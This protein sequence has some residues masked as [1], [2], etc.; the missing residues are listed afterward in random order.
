[1]RTND[2]RAT[3]RLRHPRGTTLW[4][5]ALCLAVPLSVCETVARTD[6]PQR[7]G[8]VPSVGSS[9]RQFE[10]AL[11]RIEA[12]VADEGRL[13][14][15]FLGSSVVH[16]GIDPAA[17]GGAYR[18][19]TG[20]T[21]R[22]FNFGIQGVSVATS[23][24]LAELL[25]RRYHPRLLVFG[26]TARD[27]SPYAQH[28][29]KSQVATVPWVR[30]YTGAVSPKGWLAAHSA[31]FR[32][33]LTYRNWMRAD[34]ARAMA[35]RA[36]E[37]RYT[38]REGYD[39]RRGGRLDVRGNPNP[40]TQGHYF[41]VLRDFT[42][43][44]EARDGLR[45]IARLQG[46]GIQV[47]L[48]EMPITPTTIPFFP[49]GE[50]DYAQFVDVLTTTAR[51]TGVLLWRTFGVAPVPFDGWRDWGHLNTKGARVFSEWLGGQMAAMPDVS[52]AA[53]GPGNRS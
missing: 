21:I 52:V 11:R 40:R 5:A 30:Y 26:S 51:D 24:R 14:C 34:Y 2:P 32:Y 53:E 10:I 7:W 9:H 44:P 17:L 8:L 22:C 29:V 42:I 18:K 31:A 39:T 33:Y 1:M 49:N 15:V 38:T 43:V 4:L 12:Y 35:T 25:A 28:Q 19:H 37:D 16:R 3:L 20:R 27:Y 47:A 36:E 48:L 41:G 50:R 46:S 6:L 23:S 45:R 13:D